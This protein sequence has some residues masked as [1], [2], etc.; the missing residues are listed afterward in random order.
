M[1]FLKYHLAIFIVCVL[2]FSCST[3]YQPQSVQYKDYRLTKASK[4]D[5]AILQLIKPYADSVNKSMNDIVAVNEFELEK[6]QPEGTLGNVMADAMLAMSKKYFS[7]QVDAAFINSGGIRL[8]NIPAGNITRGKVFE[9]APFDNIIVLLKV[10]GKLFQQFLNHISSRGGWPT[11]GMSW[12]IK[13][14]KAVN[15]LIAGNPIN[16]SSTYTI[17]LVDYVA[18][19]GDDCEMLKP[20]P[21]INKGNLFRDAVLDY[22]GELTKAGKKISSPIEK[23]VSYAN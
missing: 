9:L 21:Q 5:S 17:A 14:K 6:K 16:E 4:P 1:K 18:N 12:E 7:Q 19:G 13:D 2:L 8:P 3:F 10:D 20:L 15:V 11:A 23:R 22:F